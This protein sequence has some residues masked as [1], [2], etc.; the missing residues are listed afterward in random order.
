MDNKKYN[1]MLD[2]IKHIKSPFHAING[3]AF[4]QG[5]ETPAAF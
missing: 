5:K 1:I 4:P 3:M 2:S